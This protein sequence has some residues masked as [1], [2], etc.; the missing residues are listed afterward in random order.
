MF[1]TLFTCPGALRRH[2]EGPLATE[3]AAYLRSLAASGVARGTILRCSSYCFCDS[4]GRDAGCPAPPAQIRA[5]GT[6]AHGSYLGC[7]T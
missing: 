3:R 7:L 4:C 2:R 6:T 5:C 1:E